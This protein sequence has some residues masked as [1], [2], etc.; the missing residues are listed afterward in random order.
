MSLSW[1]PP[2]R[3][4]ATR[5][6]LTTFQ[7]A[8]VILP[9]GRTVAGENNTGRLERW[10]QRFMKRRGKADGGGSDNDAEPGDP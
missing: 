10:V 9:D 3:Q 2:N 5:L 4:Q 6:V 7:L 1:C 8:I